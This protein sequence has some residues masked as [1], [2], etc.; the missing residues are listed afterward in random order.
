MDLV[1][2]GQGHQLG[3]PRRAPGMEQGA[4]RVASGGHGEIER[5]GPRGVAQGVE[6][7]VPVGQGGRAAD[8]QHMPQRG[9]GREQPARLVPAVGVEVR[10]RDHQDRRGFGVQQVGNRG[11]A[12]QVVDRAG[13]PRNLRA[14]Q[15]RRQIR[16]RRGEEGGDAGP[17]IEPERA[18]QGRGLR[19]PRQQS[20][21]GER[22]AHVVRFGAAQ[23]GEG[24]AVPHGLRRRQ[25][26]VIECA[27]GNVFVVGAGFD[28]PDVVEAANGADG[29]RC[30]EAGHPAVILPCGI[31]RWPVPARPAPPPMRTRFRRCGSPHCSMRRRGRRRCPARC[32]WPRRG[33]G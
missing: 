7:C 19:D 31:R 5:I 10:R 13:H 18:E 8:H 11:G 3:P 9:H 29:A 25:Q 21:M 23:D 20:G 17:V 14:K 30:S 2:V 12:E 22:G 1:A 27:G 26:Q 6:R 4:D 15:Q 16:Q 33:S 32:R 28:G 24:R